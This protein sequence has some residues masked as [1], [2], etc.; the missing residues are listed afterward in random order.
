V[1]VPEGNKAVIFSFV[2]TLGTAWLVV[3]HF[4]FGSTS[5][6]VQVN[7]LLAKSTPPGAQK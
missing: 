7:D 5:D 3:M 1:N 2:G 6:T 4:W